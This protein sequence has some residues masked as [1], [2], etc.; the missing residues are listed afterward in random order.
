MRET[1]LKLADHQV[2]WT[3]DLL[4]VL[5]RIQKVPQVI[6]L[7]LTDDEPVTKTKI[8]ARNISILKIQSLTVTF[9]FL[10]NRK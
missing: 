4:L 1:V 8:D 9:P 10:E 3:E 2:T 7:Q 5:N 6:G